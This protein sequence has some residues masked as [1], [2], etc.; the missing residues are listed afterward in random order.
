MEYLEGLTL[1]EFLK[2][3]RLDIETSI[4]IIHHVCAALKE[5]HAVGIVHRDVSPDNIF[6]CTNN[7]I[8]LIDFGAARFSLDE[9]KLM[10]I[11]LKPGFAPPEQYEKVNVQGPWTDIYALGATLYQMVTGLKPDESTN[12]KI[13]D[14]LATPAEVDSAIPEYI[15]NTI[16]K[17]MAIDKHL[18]FVSI[19]EFEKAINQE[20]KVLPVAKEKKRRKRR[21]LITVLS[22]VVV[23]AVA[24]SI[25]LMNWNQQRDEETLPD[26]AIT[27]WYSLSGDS[28]A[29]AAKDDAFTAILAAFNSSY[30]NVT[31]DLMVYNAD[32]YASAILSAIAN[33]T[34]PT[35]FESKGLDSGVIDS[36]IDLSGV[37][38]AI[39]SEQCHFINRYASYFPQKRQLPLGFVAPVLYINTTLMDADEVSNV[40]AF[41][42]YTD[43][44]L[45]LSGEAR[46]F[47]SDT[48]V[49]FDVQRA[50]PARYRLLYVDSDQVLATFSH[51]FS[52]GNSSANERRVAE[53]LLL[54]MLSNNSQD[55]LH[56]RNR[57]GALPIN[58][59]VLD[60]FSNVYN[61]FDGFF[62]N[63]DAYIFEVK[64]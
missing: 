54:Y 31:I 16:M 46:A 56:I 64:N 29:D 23:I 45:F 13:D 10:T 14:T 4:S 34:A 48:S 28:D 19:E 6:I 30:P 41:F 52:I 35:L 61:D 18:R 36:A 51:L 43:K 38:N 2:N 50:L 32:E 21:R 25:F 55:F 22:S 8:K 62:A 42:D 15:S 3:N 9:E 63:I 57:S 12:R 17:S 40:S 53:R 1:S 11:I 26:A 27:L 37:I 58:K 44:D 60:V 59:D 33:G 20:K 24:A 47:Y 49:Y 7:I 5:I 39:N